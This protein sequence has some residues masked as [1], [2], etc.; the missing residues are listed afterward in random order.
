VQGEPRAVLITGL[1]GTGKSSVAIEMADVLE[2][3]ELPYAVVDLD[4]L[5]W[6][7]AGGAEGSEHRMMLA[8]LVPVVAN[9]LEAGVRYFIFARSIRTAAELESLRSALSMPLAV[10]ELI[11]PFSEIE[12]R[13][14]PDITAARQEDL[15]D[16]KAWLAAGDGVGLGDLSV[17]NDRPVR[18]VASDILRRLEWTEEQ[19]Y[20]R[21]G[22]EE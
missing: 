13:L 14:A 6:G 2:K 8:N 17:P 15:R 16:A 22:G 12:R 19:D 4:W 20:H 3:R 1:F 11:V 21:G 9:Y 10:V 18:A 5:C 7:W